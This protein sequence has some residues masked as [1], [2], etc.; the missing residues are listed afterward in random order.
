MFDNFYITLS[1]LFLVIIFI[2]WFTSWFTITKYDNTMSI[3]Q[4]ASQSITSV[5]QPIIGGNKCTWGPSYWC[6][7]PENAK[8]CDFPW[9]DCLKYMTKSPQSS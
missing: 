7:S 6:A 1:L 4:D 8:A 5:T 3:T 2:G 9:N